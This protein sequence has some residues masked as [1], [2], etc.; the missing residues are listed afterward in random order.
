MEVPAFGGEMG[1]RVTAVLHRSAKETEEGEAV[2]EKDEG[3][4]EKAIIT[5]TAAWRVVGCRLAAALRL[6]AEEEESDGDG[7]REAAH[8]MV[9]CCGT[10]KRYT[11]PA[12]STALPASGL[13]ASRELSESVMS[14]DTSDDEA[15]DAGLEGSA[16]RCLLSVPISAASGAAEDR[17]SDERSCDEDEA[18]YA[19]Y[20]DVDAVVMDSA[21]WTEVGCGLDAALRHA[22]N[23]AEDDS[24]DHWSVAHYGLD[25]GATFP[26]YTSPATSTALPASSLTASREQSETAMSGD[27][28]DAEFGDTD[29]EGPAFGCLLKKKR[30]RR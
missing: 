6:A 5:E 13:T 17:G 9:G 11:S 4:E 3:D 22:A 19:I 27:D 7:S 10:L 29:L 16:F 20:S 25:H 24:S 23:E 12:A 8:N 21:A 2:E 18:H 15:G 14:S 1:C 26:S 30:E 28:S